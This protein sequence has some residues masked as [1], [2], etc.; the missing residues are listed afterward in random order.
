MVQTVKFSQ[1]E[2]PSPIQAGDI[3]VGLRDVGGSLENYQFT[4]VGSGGGGGGVTM[5]ITDPGNTLQLGQWVTITTAGH[6]VPAQANTIQ[7]AECIGIVI[8]IVVVGETFVVQQSGYIDSI[9]GA[10]IGFSGLGV[11]NPYFLSNTTAGQMQQ[12]DITI[13]NEVSR[14]VFYP[15]SADS[16]W[17]LPYRGLVVGGFGST[18]GGGSTTDSNIT[19]VTQNGHGFNV[20]QWIRVTTPTIAQ[21]KY[22]LALA[23]NLGDAQSV[24]VVINVLNANQFQIQF[25][26]YNNGA[27]TGTYVD[28]GVGALIPATAY[29]LSPTTLGNITPINPSTTGLISKPLFISEQT[30]ATTGADTGWI[31]PQRPLPNVDANNNP[32]VVLVTQPGNTFAVGDWV[33]ASGAGPVYSLAIATSLATSQVSGVVIAIPPTTP[34]NTFMLQFSGYNTGAV[35]NSGISSGGGVATPVVPATVYYLS[36]TQAGAMQPTAPVTIGQFTKPVYQCEQTGTGVGSTGIY[37]GYILP[38]RPLI[39]SPSGGGGGAWQLI[40]SQTIAPGTLIVDFGAN[41]FN[42]TYQDIEIVGENIYLDDNPST[43]VNYGVFYMQVYTGGTL[44]T[45]ASYYEPQVNGNTPA[46]YYDFSAYGQTRIYTENNQPFGFKLNCYAINNT[47]STKNW[48][49]ECTQALHGAGGASSYSVYFTPGNGFG[50]QGGQN[51]E[52]A[53]ALPC[54]LGDQLPLTGVRLY[55]I[56]P[57]QILSGVISIYGRST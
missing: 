51:A 34:A 21:A 25:A 32:N 1:F 10:A 17:V 53:T 38:Q 46:T 18:S 14:P 23:D 30:V 44:R 54:Y 35:Q 36:V 26:G 4:G 19:T 39:I 56:A 3:V 28:G 27:V 7:N 15:D 8:Q 42:G 55:T 24:G 48:I 9:L 52:N 37:A 40:A 20:G 43:G 11:G 31:L 47:N 33:Y 57:F 50:N 12:L 5:T 49:T 13:T 41:I 6:Y 16:G 22:T 29:Y 45:T 2:G